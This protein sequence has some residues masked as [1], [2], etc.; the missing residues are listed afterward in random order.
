MAPIK[1]SIVLSFP[2]DR[3]VEPRAVL[4]LLF[5]ATDRVIVRGRC[6]VNTV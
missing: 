5:E 2:R 3:D 6:H 1:N 4:P